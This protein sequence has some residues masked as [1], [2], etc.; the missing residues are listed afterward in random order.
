M[1][2][3]ALQLQTEK[4]GSRAFGRARYVRVMQEVLDIYLISLKSEF[5]DSL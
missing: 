5:D 1:D 4:L 2:E 3:N